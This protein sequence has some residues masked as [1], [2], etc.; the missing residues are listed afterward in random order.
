MADLRTANERLTTYALTDALTGLPNRRA[1]FDD[2]QRL[3][4]RAVRDGTSVLVGCI[5][6]DGFKAINDRYG[7]QVGDRFLQAVA[8]RL[9]L[10]LRGSDLLA[11]MGGDEF[12][13]V[14]PGADMTD[15]PAPNGPQIDR[16]EPQ[17]A[18]RTLQQRA[19][20]ATVGRFE[21]GE[22]VLHYAGASVG[23]VALNPVGL[24]AEEALQLADARMY[25]VKRGR[26]QQAQSG[27]SGESDQSGQRVH[28]A[29]SAP[30]VEAIVPGTTAPHA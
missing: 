28:P 7:H 18:A 23:V 30:K 27:Q 13:V 29:P 24:S 2:L 14:G 5:D 8:Q 22:Q 11:R 16:G 25:E 10:E 15:A 19:T 9:S 17:L 1:L 26:H 4:N 6:L 20:L 21:L 3:L 12:V